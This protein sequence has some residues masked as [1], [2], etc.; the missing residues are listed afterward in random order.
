MAGNSAL[1]QNRRTSVFPSSL[2]KTRRC[3]LL[4]ILQADHLATTRGISWRIITW[5]LSFCRIDA[6]SRLT[7]L[8]LSDTH[9]GCKQSIER[10]VRV[11]ELSE[12]LYE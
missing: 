2:G 7:L 1:A 4:D 11:K 9:I 5:T 10:I 6:G 3:N 8:H 12:G